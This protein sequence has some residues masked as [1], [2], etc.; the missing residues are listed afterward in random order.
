MINTFNLKSCNGIKI[1]VNPIIF[2]IDQSMIY[3]ISIVQ[4]L[5]FIPKKITIIA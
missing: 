4:I 1:T 3:I 2:F 5:I